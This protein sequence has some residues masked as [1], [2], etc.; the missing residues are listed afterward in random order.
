VCEEELRV[1]SS[2]VLQWAFSIRVVGGHIF[3]ESPRPEEYESEYRTVD[4]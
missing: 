3:K 4:F 1:L 2:R